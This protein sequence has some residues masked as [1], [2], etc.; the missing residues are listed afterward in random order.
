VLWV[1]AT[2][3]VLFAAFWVIQT[4]ELWTEGVRSVGAEPQQP[5]VPAHQEQ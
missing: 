3:L 2:L 4:F 1:E 5:A